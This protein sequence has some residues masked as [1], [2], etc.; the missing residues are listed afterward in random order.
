MHINNITLK[1]FR[2]Y[3]NLSFSPVSGF[4]YLY[5]P[6]G[7]GKTNLLEAIYFLSHLRS[8]RR[9]SRNTM[10]A[11]QKRDMHLK[12]EFYRSC[13]SGSVR[14]EAAITGTDRRYKVNGKEEPNLLTYLN[15]V[16]VVVF[17]PD[18]LRIVKEGPALRRAFVDRAIAAER[19]RFLEESREYNR[20]LSERNRLLKERAKFDIMN[21]WDSRL[22]DSAAQIV[23]HRCVFLNTLR[24]LLYS[25]SQRMGIDHV[26]DISY[27]AGGVR[28]GEKKWAELVAE[29]RNIKE[30]VASIFLE[31]TKYVAAEERRRGVTLWGPHLDDFEFLFDG[32]KV[33][34]AGSQGEQRLFVILLVI[35]TAE[36]YRESEKEDPIV[37][38]DDLSSELDPG[39]TAAVLGYLENMRTQVFITSTQ[40][41]ETRNLRKPSVLYQ[42]REGT[43]TVHRG[44]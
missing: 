30:I 25:V 33:R 40:K 34:D 14:L 21:V 11:S 42:V 32:R 36:S 4:N 19:N 31:E 13:A 29:D 38:L 3:S 1:N 12:G 2:N 22:I 43:I 20:L 39:R 41:P 28:R 18:S 7:S 26:V 37:L 23:A 9:A 5:G 35:A 16:N 10:I 17:F 15:Q 27:R 24:R 8:F 44:D 6:N